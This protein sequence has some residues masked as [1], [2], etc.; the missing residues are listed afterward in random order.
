MPTSEAMNAVADAYVDAYK[1][2]DKDALLDLFAADAHFE[3]PVGQPAHIGRAAISEFWDQVHAMAQIELHRKDLIVCANEMA[4]TIEIH[5]T[6]G[7]STMV[8]DA[9]DV[10]VCNDEGKI[11]NLKAYWDMARARP[12]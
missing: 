9:I 7:D 3:D 12:H 11:T 6:M 1:R 2:A 10:F 5:A 4:M 8:M